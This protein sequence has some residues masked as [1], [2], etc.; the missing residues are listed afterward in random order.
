MLRLVGV[1]ESWLREPPDGIMTDAIIERFRFE[2]RDL[3][4]EI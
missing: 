4:F 1:R 2:I 3:R